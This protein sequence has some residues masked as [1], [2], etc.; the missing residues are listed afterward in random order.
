MT[1]YKTGVKCLVCKKGEIVGESEFN[2]A[3]FTM[4]TP[5]G[6]RV[7]GSTEIIFHCS[8]CQVLFYHPPGKPDAEV[9]IRRMI[10]SGEDGSQVE[11]MVT[12]AEVRQ[13]R[14]FLRSMFRERKKKG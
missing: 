13:K 3:P 10:R 2:A 6:G 5:I 8:R 12:R 7:P 1:T 9:E 11:G 14:S 4:H